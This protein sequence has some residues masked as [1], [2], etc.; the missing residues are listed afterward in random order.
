MLSVA[1]LAITVAL[2]QSPAFPPDTVALVLGP[3]QVEVVAVG[4]A[5]AE[6]ARLL[7][8]VVLTSEEARRRVALECALGSHSL[9]LLTPG[10]PGTRERLDWE[11]RRGRRRAAQARQ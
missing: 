7:K 1:S 3:E 10:L 9:S 8:Q 4:D 2:C 6:Y 5:Q 11:V